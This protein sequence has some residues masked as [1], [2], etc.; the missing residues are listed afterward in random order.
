MMK[1]KKRWS[2]VQQSYSSNPKLSPES[3]DDLPVFRYF[4]PTTLVVDTTCTRVK[5]LNEQQ[6]SNTW[7]ISTPSLVLLSVYLSVSVLALQARQRANRALR[8]PDSTTFQ[9]RLRLK[10]D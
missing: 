8:H 2:L 4:K 10:R 3:E 1:R 6:N 9:Q 5:L 7:A